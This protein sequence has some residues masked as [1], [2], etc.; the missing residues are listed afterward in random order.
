MIQLWWSVNTYPCLF[1]TTQ[2]EH[3]RSLC[4]TRPHDCVET[5][6]SGWLTKPMV[7]LRGNVDHRFLKNT[8]NWL[9]GEGGEGLI[10]KSPIPPI[11]QKSYSQVTNT[12]TNM[13]AN[14][15]KTEYLTW[16]NY[17]W[18]F[19]PVNVR[20]WAC[21]YHTSHLVTHNFS[22]I[23]YICCLVLSLNLSKNGLF[24]NVLSS[25]FF[26]D[27]IAPLYQSCSFWT[28]FKRP[29]NPP[30]FLLNI[31]LAPHPSFWTM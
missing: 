16:R 4:R 9:D 1:K 6:R 2:Q 8:T 11:I 29:F 18:F 14:K 10:V 13:E 17:C 24:L 15:D 28:L 25:S 31:S 26:Q 7:G 3:I 23:Y 21:R 19:E 30:T 12:K 20:W 27:R 5:L 22:K